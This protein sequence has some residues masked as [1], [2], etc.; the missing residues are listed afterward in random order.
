MT[1]GSKTSSVCSLLALEWRG[2][3]AQTIQI[4]KHDICMWLQSASFAVNFECELFDLPN[5]HTSNTRGVYKHWTEALDKL[6]RLLP[7]KSS[8]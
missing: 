3:E 1:K 4:P 7:P 2:A 8:L 5:I 6:S